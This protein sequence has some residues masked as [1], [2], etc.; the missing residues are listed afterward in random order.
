VLRHGASTDQ[1]LPSG[2]PTVVAERKTKPGE[3][4]GAQIPGSVV[5]RN[6]GLGPQGC[7]VIA[8]RAQGSTGGLRPRRRTCLPLVTGLERL[9]RVGIVTR[10]P[11]RQGVIRHRQ[12][13]PGSGSGMMHRRLQRLTARSRRHH[14]PD[15]HRRNL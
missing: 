13:R 12:G 9:D 8:V 3:A 10:P 2:R 1:P 15:R 14:T 4:D 6:S 11:H 5:P 7:G